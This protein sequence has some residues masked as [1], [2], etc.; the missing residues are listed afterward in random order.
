MEPDGPVHAVLW[1]VVPVGLRPRMVRAE[2]SGVVGP[3]LEGG[4]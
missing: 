4:G 1:C 2:G 3:E